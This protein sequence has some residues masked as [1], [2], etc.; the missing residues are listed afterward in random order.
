MIRTERR[1]RTSGIRPPA[2]SRRATL[3]ACLVLALASPV[4]SQIP[5]PTE[6]QQPLGRIVA[7]VVD[8]QTGAPITGV[9]VE[10]E[11]MQ[12][13]TVSDT[14]GAAVFL[15]LPPGAHRL[16]ASRIGYAAQTVDLD[17]EGL[18]TALVVIP[19]A[20]EAVALAPL[21]VEIEYRPRY[22]EEQGF[23][24]RRVVGH[25]QFFDP[26]FVERWNVG[27]W[28]AADRFVKLL[29]D[30]TPQLGSATG[31]SAS[32]QNAY[33]ASMGNGFRGQCPAVYVDG[34]RVF[35]D[36][37]LVKASRE[38]EMMSTYMIGAVEVYPSSQ[39]VPYFALEPE[40]GCG[41]I[42]IWTN[43]WRGRSRDL[44]GGDIELCERTAEGTTTVEGTIRDEFTGVLLPGAH[45]LA[46]SHPMGVPEMAETREI[47]ADKHGRYR[48]C[49]IPTDHSL[50]LKVATAGREGPEQLVR[51]GD[52]LVRHDISVRVA[53]PGD[54]VGRVI[55]RG[56]GRPV[57]TATISVVGEN[58]R[59]QTDPDGYFRLD[60]V[61]PG[62][63]V[64]EIE[65]L[66]FQAVAELVSIVADRT[67]D[68]RVELSADPIALE[69]LVVTALRDRRLERRGFYDRRT[70]S[71]R[72][73]LGTFFDPSDIEQM[74]P[75]VTSSLLRQAPGI[76]VRCTGARNC[77]VG[78]AR[79]GECEQMDIYVNGTLTLGAGRTDP[80]SIDELVRPSE[81]AG[82]EVYSGASS[83]PAEFSG[84]TAQCG[85]V[86]IWTR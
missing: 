9:L 82:V 77:R 13:R 21:D 39:G 1:H 45:V 47:V 85:A 24:D 55:D 23:Y 19:L 18:Q 6:D 50:G 44:G 48:V 79:S 60:D 16:V 72:T 20:T 17:V 11:S 59:T 69:P 14:S 34:Q 73:G 12:R 71:D 67:V 57:A 46:T 86:V 26:M 33:E 29:V 38:L 84:T 49:D 66:G 25:G 32:Q 65:H 76:D 78:T 63:H 75:A 58:S 53:G 62:D 31:T 70:W 4:S 52:P 61:L 27:G 36:P 68:L 2:D 83:V 7:H 10:L 37:G 5:Q 15:D 40:V 64:V 56:T 41:S 42:V 74:A 22:L 43:R 30:M 54:V 3:L 51:V 35:N 8:A 28:V 81:I 80:L